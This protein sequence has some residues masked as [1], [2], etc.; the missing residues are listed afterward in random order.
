MRKIKFRGKNYK[1]KWV[2]GDLVQEKWGA[3]KAIMIKKDKRAW[4][5]LENTVSQ[6]TGM[7]DRNGIEIYEGDILQARDEQFIVEYDE[8]DGKFEAVLNNNV[9]DFSA[10]NSKWFEVIGNKYD[11]K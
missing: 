6:F 7:I 4:S 10:L 11:K 5:V 3:G 2:Y 9:Y 8:E 1:C